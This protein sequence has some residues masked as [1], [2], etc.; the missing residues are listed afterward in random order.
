MIGVMARNFLDGIIDANP[1]IVGIV[2]L[3]L[4]ILAAVHVL[5][6]VRSHGTGGD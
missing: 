3:A 6:R 5:R 4:G 2:I 1:T